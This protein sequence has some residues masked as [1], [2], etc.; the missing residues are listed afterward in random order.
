MHANDQLHI[1]KAA[2]RAPAG[3][4]APGGTHSQPGLPDGARL[5]SVPQ[6]PLAPGRAC[7]QPPPTAPHCPQNPNLGPG[8]CALAPGAP[9]AHPCWHPLLQR[10]CP[11][12][13]EARL[14]TF[15]HL[16]PS[17]TPS[18]AQ[19]ALLGAEEWR[20]G[21]TRGTRQ[22]QVERPQTVMRGGPKGLRAALTN[23]TG[24]DREPTQAQGPLRRSPRGRRADRPAAGP[25]PPDEGRSARGTA[26]SDARAWRRSPR[27]ASL[28]W[29]CRGPPSRLCTTALA[30]R[31]RWPMFPRLMPPAA[32]GEGA[33]GQRGTAWRSVGR[34][35]PQASS[36]R[37]LL[38]HVLGASAPDSTLH[39]RRPGTPGSRRGRESCP[40]ASQDPGRLR[41]NRGPSSGQQQG[42]LSPP[43]LV[44]TSTPTRPFLNLSSAP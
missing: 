28:T 3:S 15:S 25:V 7:P 16:S 23:S 18:S 21:Y 12:P 29:L 41:A 33:S 6:R 34:R 4:G 24:L 44:A 5:L 1:G 26:G 32:L 36:P 42:W 17:G 27:K 40:R 30:I 20:L 31:V 8:L 14:P 2:S 22:P 43:W 37:S 38:S 39:S 11:P 13:R 19:D 9:S 35:L 10:C